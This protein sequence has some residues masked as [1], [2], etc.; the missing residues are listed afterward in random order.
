MQT[1]LQTR[2]KYS[3]L[4]TRDSVSE[5]FFFFL[6][7][8]G[9]REKGQHTWSS[10]S[11][12][13]IVLKIRCHELKGMWTL[14][15]LFLPRITSVFTGPSGLLPPLVNTYLSYQSRPQAARASSVLIFVSVAR[16]FCFFWVEHKCG[17]QSVRSGSPQ[18]WPLLTELPRSR[19][20]RNPA[21][22]FISSCWLTLTRRGTPSPLKKKKR[23]TA[24]TPNYGL[25]AVLW[26]GSCRPDYTW[27]WFVYSCMSLTAARDSLRF[28]QRPSGLF[29]GFYTF[30]LLT[31]ALVVIQT[32]SEW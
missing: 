20:F 8:E 12:T 30:S 22:S 21:P 26:C 14:T 16:T 23:G 28:V 7:S 3:L 13:F 29:R 18:A 1:T 5:M 10:N 6:F 15:C 31:C 32:R 2:R 27:V 9:G 24:R 11:K 4:D 19:R 17:W 25:H